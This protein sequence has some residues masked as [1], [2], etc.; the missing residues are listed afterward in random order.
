MLS[1][2]PANLVID[3]TAPQSQ[4]QQQL[5]PAR[6]QFL[7]L[8]RLPE[9]IW[10]LILQHLRRTELGALGVDSIIHAAEHRGM[11]GEDAF[12]LIDACTERLTWCTKTFTCARNI[13]LQD[14][15]DL[16]LAQCHF[17]L[18][19]GTATPK[20][21][22]PDDVSPMWLACSTAV[23]CMVTA[24]EHITGKLNANYEPCATPRFVRATGYDFKKECVVPAWF[25]DHVFDSAT[26]TVYTSYLF[27]NDLGVVER[28]AEDIVNVCPE[29]CPGGSMYSQ[30]CAHM[31]RVEQARNDVQRARNNTCLAPAIYR[32]D[33]EPLVREIGQDYKTGLCFE[34]EAIN[35]IHAAAESYI[36]QNAA[37]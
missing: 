14:K 17:I 10:I 8:P 36:V 29:L 3:R 34:A 30:V 33:F 18:L 28:L 35:A 22:P 24:L 27:E 11:E 2:K 31:R 26:N 19:A 12:R 23:E 13:A 32:A 4:Q 16:M 21:P 7:K 9:E 6:P 20:R 5:A 25:V 1:V 37:W 15:V